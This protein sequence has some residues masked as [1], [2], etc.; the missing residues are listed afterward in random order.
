MES[1]S[2]TSVDMCKC[3]TLVQKLEN[4]NSIPRQSPD[5]CREVDTRHYWV[6]S[7]ERVH[8][9]RAGMV[10]IRCERSLEHNSVVSPNRLNET[11]SMAKNGSV[12]DG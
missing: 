10:M 11:R 6:Q 7:N 5:G 8:N 9:R 4:L 1:G 12:N 2:G 3:S